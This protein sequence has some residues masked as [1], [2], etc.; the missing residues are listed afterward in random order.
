M[1]VSN[2][3][4]NVVLNRVE[5]NVFTDGACKRMD[6]ID[7]VANRRD[8]VIPPS[9]NVM[10]RKELSNCNSSATVGT[11]VEDSLCS[12]PTAV[13]VKDAMMV[14][15]VTNIE[16]CDEH[17]QKCAE[18]ASPPGLI[19]SLSG[20][21]QEF[22]PGINLEVHLGQLKSDYIVQ[23]PSPEINEFIM[24]GPNILPSEAQGWPVIWTALGC[25]C[26][27]VMGN[28][29]FSFLSEWEG[30]QVG[31]RCSVLLLCSA[32]VNLDVFTAA[33]FGLLC[34]A[35]W[36]GLGVLLQ[37]WTMPQDDG[38]H[39]EGSHIEGINLTSE[40]ET[41]VLI[42]GCSVLEL[43]MVWEL[44]LSQWVIMKGC[45]TLFKI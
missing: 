8:S 1:G 7:T 6:V 27:A 33:S 40:V 17:P 19:K 32:G 5:E 30:C 15:R 35:V 24:Q 2:I 14:E 22:G 31:L 11:V 44:L 25:G 39:T 45:S 18:Q 34:V 29:A 9:I 26:Y 37:L 20:S 3:S 13:G 21:I 38:S 28:L 12:R 16:E 4:S 36:F 10:H 43:G 23:G 41:M 42:S